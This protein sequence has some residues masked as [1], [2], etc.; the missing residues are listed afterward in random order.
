MEEL[1]RDLKRTQKCVVRSGLYRGGFFV[2]P[3]K[4]FPFIDQKNRKSM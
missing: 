1:L 4:W 3:G 2:V